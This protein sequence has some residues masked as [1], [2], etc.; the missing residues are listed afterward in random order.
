MHVMNGASIL[1]EKTDLDSLSLNRKVLIDFYYP[2]GLSNFQEASLLLINDGQDMET[3][4][5]SAIL[6]DLTDIIRPLI[7][8]AIHASTERKME[9]GVAGYPDFKGRG[10]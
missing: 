8:V 3:L 2:N 5:L 6:A 4:G 7:C 1:V 10:A 9:Y